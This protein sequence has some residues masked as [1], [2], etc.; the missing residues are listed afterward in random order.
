MTAGDDLHTLTGAYALN[1]LPD[2]ERARFEEHL[3]GC[4]PCLDEVVDLQ[5]ATARLGELAYEPPSSELRDRVLEQIDTIP[6]ERPAAAGAP[7]PASPDAPPGGTPHG[8][9]DGDR[10]GP[11]ASRP[12]TSLE[13]RRP[14]SRWVLGVAGAA[15]AALVVAVAGLAVVVD[16]L[17]DQLS[18]A[19]T[20]TRDL[21]EVLAAPDASTVTAE[22]PDGAVA[23]VVASPQMGEAV[24][25]S[26]DMPPAPH[27]HT[28][29]AW[30]IDDGFTSVGLFD[31][32]DDGR[33]MHMVAGDLSQTTAIGVTVEPDGGSPQP[34]TDPVMVFELG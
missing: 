13:G 6:Q 29:E 34:T 24:L 2:D 11:A 16:D 10:P 19:E 28:Y 25:V 21:E 3:E 23:R 14:V 20:M 12:V 31:P 15:A 30:L 18:D 32:G 7:T 8:T 27:G 5:A 9:A 1:A 26:A 17:S 33:A 22:A 4:R